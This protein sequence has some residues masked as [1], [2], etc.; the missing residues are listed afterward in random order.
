MPVAA[1]P[2][3]APPRRPPGPLR[4]GLLR[5]WPWLADV[6]PATLRADAQAGL[7][8]AVL[9]LPQGIAFAALAGLPPAMGLAAAALP[10]AVAALGGSSRQVMT[11]PSNATALALGAMLLPLAAGDAG[12]LLPLALA[13]TLLVGLMQVGLALAGA[14]RRWMPGRKV[15]R[16]RR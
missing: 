2:T 6:S 8:G 7:L 10:C 4:R 9:V 11:G 15:C 3:A 5:P 1:D 16:C 12:L 14:P 13:L